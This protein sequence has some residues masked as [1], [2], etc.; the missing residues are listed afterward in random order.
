M[1]PNCQ[2]VK[3]PDILTNAQQKLPTFWKKNLMNR[4]GIDK[5]SL[6]VFIIF[7]KQVQ[8]PVE[9]V[10]P[11]SVEMLFIQKMNIINVFL[12][13]FEQKSHFLHYIKRKLNIIYNVFLRKRKKIVYITCIKHHVFSRS[14]PI[15][16]MI[17]N[18]FRFFMCSNP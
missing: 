12:I 11:D 17:N 3:S 2:S 4:E 13:K 6:L 15:D 16:I 8:K 10:T 18:I 5:S 14:T 1:N 9:Y 7:H